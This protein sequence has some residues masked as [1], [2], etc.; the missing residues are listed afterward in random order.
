MDFALAGGGG[1][2]LLDRGLTGREINGNTPILYLLNA[3]DEY[4]K[5]PNEWTS[6]K[7][8]HLLP[9]ALFPHAA[10]W[11]QASIPRSAWEYNQPP[12]VIADSTPA[13]FVSYLETSENI[14]VEAIRREQ[15]HIEMRFAESLGIPGTASVKLNLPHGTVHRTDFNGHV[16]SAIPGSG[17]YAIPVAPQQIITLQ[18]ETDGTLPVPGPVLSWEEFVPERKRSALHAYDPNVKGHPPFGGGSMEF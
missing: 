18:F 13:P 11:A 14:V 4:H 1:I 2:A 7:G 5:F 17:T 6:G 15:D 16:E 10:P 3:E 12:I 9:Y 8:R